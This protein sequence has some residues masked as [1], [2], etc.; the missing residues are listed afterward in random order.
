MSIYYGLPEQL[1]KLPEGSVIY[2]KNNQAW[3][4]IDH[5]WWRPGDPTAY[6]SNEIA[7][8]ARLLDD[9]L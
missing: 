2:D 5:A 6:G 3:Q 1:D 8:P 9:G 7:F 4:H